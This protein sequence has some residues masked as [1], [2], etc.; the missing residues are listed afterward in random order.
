M[1]LPSPDLLTEFAKLATLT[2]VAIASAA[3]VA[4]TVVDPPDRAGSIEPLW[5]TDRC[6]A[7]QQALMLKIPPE[8][9]ATRIERYDLTPLDAQCMLAADVPEVIWVAAMRSVARNHPRYR[10]VI[11]VKP[12]GA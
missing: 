2:I 10:D 4:I 9:I 5:E 8:Q 3:G 12:G 11:W 6:E 1:A 7:V